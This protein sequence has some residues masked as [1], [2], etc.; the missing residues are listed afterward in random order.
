[1]RQTGLKLIGI[2]QQWRGD[3][4]AGLEALHRLL[5]RHPE[6]QGEVCTGEP[7]ALLNA[8]A[9]AA[10][11]VVLD[12]M[13]ASPG[14]SRPVFIDG[15]DAALLPGGRASTHNLSL[16][17]AVE[18]GRSLDRLPARLTV[19]AI[20]GHRF[21]LGEPLSVET[22]QALAELET[23]FPDWLDRHA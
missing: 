3:D 9:G 21:G 11:V 14:A 16:A 8:F 20:P 2:G 15:L 23:L 12:C 19:I 1:M 5:A 6:L 10:H 17:E 4:G 7:L 18:L 22:R 13:A